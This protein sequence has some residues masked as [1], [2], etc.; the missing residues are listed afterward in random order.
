[1]ALRGARRRAVSAARKLQDEAFEKRTDDESFLAAYRTT[2]RDD[3][4]ALYLYG[5]AFG[6]LKRLQEASAEFDA[7]RLA[8]P[9]NPYA[10]EGLGIAASMR[11]Q[12]DSAVV[13][14]RKA[15]EID[16]ECA[17]ARFALAQTLKAAGRAD[18]ALSEALEC[19]R[20]D[21][22]PGRAALLA[23]ELH[24]RNHDAKRAVEVLEPAL[25]RTPTSV[26]LRL[27]MA[28]ALDRAGKSEEAAKQLEEVLTKGPIPPDRLEVLA[29]LYRRAEQFD[30]AV[31]LLERVLRDAPDSYWK[32]HARD[33]V[34]QQLTMVRKEKEAGHRIDYTAD[35]LIRILES[36]P[37][38]ERRLFALQALR[39]LPHV[40]LAQVF[41]NALKDPSPE[42]R[43]AAVRE[44]T[45]RVGDLA[46]KALAVVARMDRDPRVRA[47]ALEALARLATDDANAVLL[48]SLVDS[49]AHVREVA[50]RALELL[51]GRI[52]LVGSMDSLDDEGRKRLMAEWSEYLRTHPRKSGK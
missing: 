20:T 47:T 45:M 15:L 33:A 2:S 39:S 24:L 43:M 31:E 3:S 23:S 51:T 46:S 9:Q 52:L 17:D 16:P 44:V 36:H 29:A 38:A 27:A 19:M 48:E 40:E 8:D 28:D 6:K 7:A 10:Y 41:A 32:L 11:D 50:N 30:R 18:E 34:E 22:D 13:A 5:R 35:E 26:P 14:L 21:E 12:Y 1:M 49:D 42:V 25:Q 37:N 4:V